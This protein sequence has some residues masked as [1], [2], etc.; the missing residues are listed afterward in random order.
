MI[1]NNEYWEAKLDE[2]ICNVWK[3]FCDYLKAIIYIN[4]S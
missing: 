2:F 3:A 4:A 1:T